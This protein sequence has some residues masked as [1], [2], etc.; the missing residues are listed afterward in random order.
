MK[1]VTCIKSKLNV[2]KIQKLSQNKIIFLLEI[3]RPRQTH[4]ESK[5]RLKWKN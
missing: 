1:T 3:Q 4:F 2:L 5:S